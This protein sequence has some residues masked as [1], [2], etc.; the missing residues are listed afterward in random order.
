MDEK[1]TRGVTVLTY[2]RAHFQFQKCSC[3]QSKKLFILQKYFTVYV[4]KSLDD[5]DHLRSHP[6]AVEDVL[7]CRAT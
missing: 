1:P 5:L 6:S 2:L 3:K 7:S 4:L